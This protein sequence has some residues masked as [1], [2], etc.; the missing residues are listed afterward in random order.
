MAL[1]NMKEHSFMQVKAVENR[2]AIEEDIENQQKNEEF[3][4]LVGTMGN[5]I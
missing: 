5:N 4:F 3:L 1:T 2:K